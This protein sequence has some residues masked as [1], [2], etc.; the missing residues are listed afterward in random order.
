MTFIYNQ[1]L[2]LIIEQASVKSYKD[3]DLGLGVHTKQIFI[4]TYEGKVYITIDGLGSGSVI[5]T[6]SLPK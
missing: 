2:G 5:F 1:N 4:I 3:V 6:G